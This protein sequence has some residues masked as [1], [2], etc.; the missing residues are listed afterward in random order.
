MA[1]GIFLAENKVRPGAYINFKAARGPAAVTGTRGV[2][3]MA[4]PMTWGPQDTIITLDSTD[5]IDGKCIKKIGLPVTDENAQVYRQALQHSFKAYVYRLD[6]NGKKA[7]TTAGALTA[8]AKYNGTAGN[9]LAIKV[10][11]TDDVFMVQTYYRQ[12]LVDSQS[13]RTAADL[14]PNDWVDFTGS[15]NLTATAGTMLTG[16]ENGTVA[17]EQYA[18]FMEKIRPYAFHTI[19]LPTV[20]NDTV[21]G[22]VADFVRE[23][24]ES[25]GK[26]V[27]AVLPEYPQA[28]YEGIISVSQGYRTTSEEVGVAGTVA[29]IAGLTAGS[30]VNQSNTYHVIDNAVEVIGELQDEQI[31]QGLTQGKLL[32]SVRQDGAVVIEKDINTLTTYTE[33]RSAVYS[34]NRVLRC[35]DDIANHTRGIFEARYIGKVD[36]T[37]NGRNVLKA[38][39]TGYLNELQNMGAITIFPQRIFRSSRAWTSNPWL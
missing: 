8:I 16:G 39:L 36:N 13:G 29:Y 32:L 10:S 7:R 33:D 31:E 37:E 2:V 6:A 21:K 4:V 9:D 28:D 25:K 12:S 5:L 11:Q 30:A 18:A 35:L 19:C 14:Q 26:K 34:K 38:D 17:E 23:L 22:A 15:G 3:A 1:G 24:R 27:Q 20:I